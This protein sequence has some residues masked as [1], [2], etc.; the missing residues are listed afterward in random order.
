MTKYLPVALALVAFATLSGTPALSKTAYGYSYAG[1]QMSS[2]NS[3]SETGHLSCGYG[4]ACP[5]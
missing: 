3:S 5:R 2:S 4:S 1:G